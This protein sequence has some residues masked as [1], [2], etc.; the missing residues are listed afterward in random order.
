[1][2]RLPAALLA[3]ALVLSTTGCGKIFIGGVLGGSGIVQTAS[4][5]VSVVQFTN[6]TNNATLIVVTLVTFLQSGTANTFTFCG[7]QR[8]QF[9]INQFVLT[10]F[11]PGTPCANILTV[12]IGFN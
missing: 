12:E 6:S 7:D 1:M 9:P 5:F 8:R 4:G 3:V 11:T 2:R 10:S